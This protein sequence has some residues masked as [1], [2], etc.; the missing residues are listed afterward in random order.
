[1]DISN[2]M[3][4]FLGQVL[5]IFTF[6]LGLLGNITFYGTSL[7]ELIVSLL[8]LGVVLDII[9]ISARSRAVRDVSRDRGSSSKGE[10]ND[11]K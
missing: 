4:W 5:K 1:M 8:V 11:D 10:S 7:L 6:C 9:V 2:F 3:S